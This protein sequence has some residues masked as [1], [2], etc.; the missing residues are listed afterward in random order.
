ME[1]SSAENEQDTTADDEEEASQSSKSFLMIQTDRTGFP[2]NR[3][4]AKRYASIIKMKGD[5]HHAK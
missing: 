4:R 1:R 5:T 2:C 3:K